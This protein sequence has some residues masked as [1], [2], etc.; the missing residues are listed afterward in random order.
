MA[1]FASSPA[2][3][4]AIPR[5]TQF[6]G[7]QLRKSGELDLRTENMGMM[8]QHAGEI[9]NAVPRDPLA[10][11]AMGY[12]HY[13]SNQYD[14]AIA[15]Y[16]ASLAVKPSSFAWTEL[17]RT[18]WATNKQDEALD[19]AEKALVMNDKEAVAWLV[20]GRV[21]AARGKHTDARIAAQ[22]AVDRDPKDD[23][24]RT[25]LASLPTMSEQR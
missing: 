17:A 3:T 9:L 5:P 24:S 6:S 12:V 16:R 23:E 18:F 19:A 14:Q 21:L 1:T 10:H 8:S 4:P 13:M 15:S 2:K 7:L 25:F 20:K 22:K 11:F